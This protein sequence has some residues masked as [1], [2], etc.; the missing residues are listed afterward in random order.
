MISIHPE[1][2]SL[3]NT[4]YEVSESI[5]VKAEQKGLQI[6]VECPDDIYLYYDAKWTAEALF[7]I[8]DNSVKYTAESEDSPT[9]IGG[10]L[11]HEKQD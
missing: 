8:V 4:L 3:R 7:N 5:R 10:E 6:E 9:S 11:R 1:R 2:N